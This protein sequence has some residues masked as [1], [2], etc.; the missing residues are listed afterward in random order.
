M[1]RASQ[2][3]SRPLLASAG[4]VSLCGARPLPS[5]RIPTAAL[6]TIAASASSRAAGASA[7]RLLGGAG[8]L[9]AGQALAGAKR[10]ATTASGAENAAANLR[11]RTGELAQPPCGISGQMEGL[12]MEA[13]QSNAV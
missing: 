1:L 7:G 9:S 6:S 10:S 13:I 3:A 11:T 2:T 5:M 12:S 4:R 8:A